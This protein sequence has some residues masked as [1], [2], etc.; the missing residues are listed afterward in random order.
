MRNNTWGV[1]VLAI[2]IGTVFG[3]SSFAQS[4]GI[5]Q[6]LWVITNL[7]FRPTDHHRFRLQVQP[8]SNDLIG[9]DETTDRDFERVETQ[10]SFIYRT[11][12]EGILPFWIGGGFTQVTPLMENIRGER[13]PYLEIVPQHRRSTEVGTVSFD[14]RTRF[15]LRFQDRTA[16]QS[17]LRIR[18]LV[19]FEPKSQPMPS[20]GNL[21]FEGGMEL[22]TTTSGASFQWIDQSRFMISAG[23][24]IA[25]L[26]LSI[27][28]GPMVR[29]QRNQSTLI[30]QIQ[31]TYTL[32]PSTE[33]LE[34]LAPDESP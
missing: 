10:G 12:R 22:F 5:N 29:F 33:K 7:D 26:P 15:E 16:A 21:F 2:W 4:S 3:S 6:Q 24:R 13:R 1:L 30:G 9:E 27:A 34:S 32:T 28:L 25:N 23:I 8:R 17:R 18:P 20:I 11:N 19:A 14:L 31:L